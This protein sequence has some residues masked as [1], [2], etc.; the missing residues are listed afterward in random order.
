LHE[1]EEAE[2]FASVEGREHALR[3]GMWTFLATEILLFAGIFALYSAYRTMYP[4]DFS[5]AIA[6]NTVAYGTTNTY[7]LIT[8]SFTVALT[9]WAARS[10]RLRWIARLLWVTA[11]FGV[12]FL[13]LKGFEYAEHIRE[14]ILPGIWYRSTEMPGYG[15]HMFWNLYWF[16]TALHAL[17]VTAGICVLLW[18]SGRARRGAYTEANHV[19]L[20]MG[21]LYWHLVDI[22][23]IFLWPLLY[24]TH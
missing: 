12:A 18:M 9:I 22:V 11:G 7:L 15:A 21:T 5:E 17:H 14:G 19:W 2:Q 23:W 6:H 20:E 24:L 10:D 4:H 16:A 13:V 1:L 8:S 3:L